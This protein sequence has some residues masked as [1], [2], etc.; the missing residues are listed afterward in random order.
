MGLD[1]SRE[2]T[3]FRSQEVIQRLRQGVKGAASSYIDLNEKIADRLFD[4]GQRMA[5]VVEETP[6]YPLIEL[7][8]T[9]A[10]KAFE[11]WLRGARLL[12]TKL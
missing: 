10:R 5:E 11:Y 6:L 1:A 9:Y 7:Q 8:Q 2:Q 4:A 3:I 12:V